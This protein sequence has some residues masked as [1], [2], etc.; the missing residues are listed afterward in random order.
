MMASNSNSSNPIEFLLTG[1]ANAHAHYINAA[2]K[3]FSNGLIFSACLLL[4]GRFG[5]IVR[6]C[7]KW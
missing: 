2:L 6:S 1:H 7:G 3:E 4:C 5:S